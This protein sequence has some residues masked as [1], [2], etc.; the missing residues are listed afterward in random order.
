MNLIHKTAVK[1]WMDWLLGKN[2]CMDVNNATR[3]P[4]QCKQTGICC[5]RV[6]YN[7]SLKLKLTLKV[8]LFCLGA[9]QR[10]KV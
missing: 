3:I 7:C 4:R 8:F 10:V 2:N 6:F 1:K 9:V 5:V